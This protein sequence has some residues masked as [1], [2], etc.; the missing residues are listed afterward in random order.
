VPVRTPIR[1]P[2]EPA[3][4]VLPRAAPKRRFELARLVP[5]G[6]ATAITLAVVAAAVGAYL[7]ARQTSL[8]AVETIDVRGAS[9]DVAGQVRA[10]LADYRGSS[11][12]TLDGAGVERRIAAL[13]VVA[14]ARYDRDFP[15]T[16]RIFVKP[17]RPVAVVRRGPDS[18][19]V[20]ARGRVIS[21]LRLGEKSPLPR[22]W[23]PGKVSVSAGGTLGGDPARAVAAAAPLA[24]SL[25]NGRV[26]VVRSTPHQIL[27][28]LRSGLE[29][30][31]GDEQNL[32]LK[33]A[34]GARIAA[35]A[36]H[37]RG[38]VD[39]TVPDRPVSHFDPK[40]GG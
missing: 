2:A 6:R 15:H 16:L 19:L 10:A 14:A 40:P 17:E 18:W 21:S 23:I 32:P 22:I 12:V 7:I 37:L 13:P 35:S 28:R 3:V 33:L 9:P 5:S 8:F 31:L 20:S 30:R 39:L 25:L 27:L 26:A 34:I 4:A 38:Y 29:L 1:L 24:H 11:L 36:H